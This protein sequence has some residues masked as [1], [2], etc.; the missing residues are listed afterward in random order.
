LIGY[1]VDG[2]GE[3]VAVADGIVPGEVLVAVGG[4]PVSVGVRDPTGVAV[5]G[6]VPV[7][8]ALGKTPV[9]RSFK[10]AIIVNGL[11]R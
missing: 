11:R 6:R 8:V 10:R 7:I 1:G 4:V 5:A 2:V 3:I 9:P